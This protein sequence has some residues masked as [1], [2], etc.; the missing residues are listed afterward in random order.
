MWR[1]SDANSYQDLVAHIGKEKQL[2]AEGKPGL[3]NPTFVSDLVRVELQAGG[4]ECLKGPCDPGTDGVVC[5]R[6]LRP[7]RVVGPLQ[8]E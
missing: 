5:I 4:P 8:M 1:I 2:A 6:S 7:F 3:G